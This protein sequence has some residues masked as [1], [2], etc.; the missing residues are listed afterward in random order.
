MS[1]VCHAYISDNTIIPYEE[2]LS[3]IALH[4]WEGSSAFNMEMAQFIFSFHEELG[5]PRY[6]VY[7]VV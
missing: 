4:N 6:V 1:N 7:H 3:P 5:F 2:F